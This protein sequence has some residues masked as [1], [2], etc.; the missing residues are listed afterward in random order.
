M[1][2]IAL[3]ILGSYGCQ[4]QISGGLEMYV[5]SLSVSNDEQLPEGVSIPCC[6]G[7]GGVG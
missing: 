6:V 7:G 4:S 2:A 5:T 3:G 1:F